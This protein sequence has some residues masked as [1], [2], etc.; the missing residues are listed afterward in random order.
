MQ[1]EIGVRIHERNNS[2]GTKV[3]E[4]GTGAG[5]G[6][7]TEIPLQPVVQSI[8]RQLCCC[9]LWRTS[10][11][12]RWMP[13]GGCYPAGSLCWKSLLEAYVE[14]EAHAWSRFDGRN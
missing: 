5:A 8:V 4:G 1:L 14:R 9:S 10:C 6:V 2:A 11:W 13:E 12:N 7:R 3:S